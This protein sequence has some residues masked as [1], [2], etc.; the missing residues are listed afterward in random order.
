[1]VGEVGT[2]W[3]GDSMEAGADVGIL[4]VAV[5]PAGMSTLRVKVPEVMDQSLTALP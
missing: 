4:T 3:E 5:A 2:A 1:V